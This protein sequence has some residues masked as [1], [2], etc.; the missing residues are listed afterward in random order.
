MRKGA[1]GGVVCG[2]GEDGGRGADI[3]AAAFQ[4]L[5][6]DVVGDLLSAEPED[7]VDGDL[8]VEFIAL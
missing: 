6:E 2:A 8:Q 7:G 3:P 5:E 4:A 1:A